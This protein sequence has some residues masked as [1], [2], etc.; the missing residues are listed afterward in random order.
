M[1][2]NINSYMKSCTAKVGQEAI[3]ASM[4]SVTVQQRDSC[5]GVG[6]IRVSALKLIRI[7]ILTSLSHLIQL[8]PRQVLLA[9]NGERS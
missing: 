6:I 5:Q 3:N 1:P 2:L 8:D 9:A 7:R 4:E